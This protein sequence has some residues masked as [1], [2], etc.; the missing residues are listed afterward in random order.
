MHRQMWHPPLDESLLPQ[1]LGRNERPERIGEEID[2]DRFALLVDG[3]YSAD[4]G[5]PSCPPLMM[6]KV[7]PLEQWYNLSDPQMEEAPGDRVSFRR[8]VGLRLQDDTPDH[9][10]IGRFRADLD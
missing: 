3:T 5:R 7:L 1:T 8:L 6:V 9:W 4:E 2:W 10:T